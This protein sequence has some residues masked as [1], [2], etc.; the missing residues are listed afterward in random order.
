[1]A[2]ISEII[3]SG[4][5]EVIVDN[6]I[7]SS[8]A[9]FKNTLAGIFYLVVRRPMLILIW[10]L[11]FLCCYHFP[12]IFH[13]SV[14]FTMVSIIIGILLFWDPFFHKQVSDCRGSGALKGW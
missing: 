11:C 9:T 6:M 13:V 4:F 5:R 12:M 14:R 7:E 10:R 8:V 1:M 2:N 3:C